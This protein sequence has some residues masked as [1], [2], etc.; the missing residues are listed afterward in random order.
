MIFPTEALADR[1]DHLWQ[2]RLCRVLALAELR[3]LQNE[4]RLPRRSDA[5]AGGFVGF[6]PLPYQPENNDIPV[7]TPS[8][9]LSTR[10]GRRVAC[11]IQNRIPGDISE[12]LP[13]GRPLT[14]RGF[15]A[16]TLK[17]TAV[18]STGL[19]ACD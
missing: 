13:S 3:A 17:L 2:H 16:A 14:A 10:C 5:K 18:C 4:A 19:T 8:T 12:I 9:R 15:P 6:V 11:V 7:K 1:V